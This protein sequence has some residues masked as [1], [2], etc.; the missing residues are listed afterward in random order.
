M[1]R[2]K[3]AGMVFRLD[4]GA[5]RTFIHFPAPEG[6]FRYEAAVVDAPGF[7]PRF[8]GRE[9]VRPGPRDG[10]VL[11]PW[12]ASLPEAGT[13]RR[14]RPDRLE[15]GPSARPAGSLPPMRRQA[16]RKAPKSAFLPYARDRDPRRRRSCGRSDGET[17]MRSPML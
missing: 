10:Q 17:L 5:A 9:A 13:A 1:E 2:R 6:T 11:G 4:P 16:G 15:G 14:R 12:D 7:F 3:S 8:R